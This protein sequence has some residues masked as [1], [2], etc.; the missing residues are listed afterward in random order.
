MKV[1]RKCPKSPGR[2]LPGTRLNAEKTSFMLH[3]QGMGREHY[4]NTILVVGPSVPPL[5]TNSKI[6]LRS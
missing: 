3:E 5:Q 2:T 4:K 6:N 1:G